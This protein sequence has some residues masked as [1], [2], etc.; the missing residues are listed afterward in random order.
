MSNPNFSM[1]PS[2]MTTLSDLGAK[3]LAADDIRQLFPGAWWL[4]VFSYMKTPLPP[5]H[6]LDRSLA[7]DGI[8][9]GDGPWA[10][11]IHGDLHASLDLDFSTSDYKS[12]LLV[13]QG[14]VRCRNFRFTNGATCVV[15]QDLFASGYVIGR[16]GDETAR[17]EVG[18]TLHA[19]ALL[20]DH[21]TG[22]EANEI[23]AITYAADGWGLPQDI[24]DDAFVD[25]E[26]DLHAVWQAA[27]T[28]TPILRPEREAELRQVVAARLAARA[29]PS[30]SA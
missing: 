10:L 9:A 7:V 21:V 25:G 27:I 26:L 22:V 3:H 11:I 5:I 23:D 14:N 12:S 18:G 16:Y 8:I 20:L 1:L 24:D 17:L 2:S 13:V 29:T 15:A 30:S 28:N 6:F 19:R 4:E